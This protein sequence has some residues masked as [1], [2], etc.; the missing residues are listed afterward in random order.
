MCG[1]AAGYK[2]ETNLGDILVADQTYDGST[3][4]ITTN[5]DTGDKEFS[6]NPTP[7]SLDA[8]LKEKIRK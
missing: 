7:L 2:S 8:D 3:G 1:I 5:A 6:P 4:K